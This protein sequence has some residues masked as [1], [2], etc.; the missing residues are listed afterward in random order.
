MRQSNNI[1]EIKDE[2]GVNWESQND[3]GKDFLNYFSNLFTAKALID[4]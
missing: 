1:S 4:K 3:I 2:S